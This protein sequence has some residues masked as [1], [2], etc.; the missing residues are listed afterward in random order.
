MRSESR[1]EEAEERDATDVEEEE[2]AEARELA[3]EE[4]EKGAV[5]PPSVTRSR[6]DG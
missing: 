6:R 4:A 1:R 2:V 5:N 3:V